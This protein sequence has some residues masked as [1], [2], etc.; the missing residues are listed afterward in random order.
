MDAQGVPRVR[1]RGWQQQSG[2]SLWEAMEQY[3][4]SDLLHVLCTDIE[5]DGALQ[6]P[7]LALYGEALRRW[8]HIQWQASGGVGSGADLHALRACG[9]PAAISGKA[10]LEERISIAELRPFLPNA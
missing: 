2:L 1:T 7:N 4:D 8:A 3:A 6:G 10:L 9:V 5:R